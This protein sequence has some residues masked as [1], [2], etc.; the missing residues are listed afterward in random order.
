MEV[1][2][3]DMCMSIIFVL[4]GVSW[5]RDVHGG[6]RVGWESGMFGFDWLNVI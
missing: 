5:G 3:I 6:A 4:D 2:F 1:L